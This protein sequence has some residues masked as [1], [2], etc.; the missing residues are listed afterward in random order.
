MENKFREL[1]ESRLK[2][3]KTAEGN[4][5]FKKLVEAAKEKKPQ[6]LSP[7]VQKK[8]ETFRELFKKKASE[9]K[10]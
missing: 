3:M 4:M 9:N 7:E 1:L 10:E 8:L 5:K 2:N 6:E